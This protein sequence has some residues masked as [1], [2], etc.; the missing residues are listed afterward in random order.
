MCGV[1]ESLGREVRGLLLEAFL[2][3][4]IVLSV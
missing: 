3:L 2:F 4:G 1:L